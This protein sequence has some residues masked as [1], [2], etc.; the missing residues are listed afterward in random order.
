M[1]VYLRKSIK[2]GPFRVNLSKSGIGVSSGIP[3][4]RVGS[5][6]R[7]SYVRMGK[8]GVYYRKTLSSSSARG[9]AGG[10]TVPIHQAL[11]EVGSNV[12]LHDVTGADVQQLAEAFQTELTMQ[13]NEAAGTA[14]LMPLIV[15][16]YILIVTIPLGLWLRARNVARRNVVVFYDVNDQHLDK[17]ERL[18]NG[19]GRAESCGARWS[20]S[21]Q[22]AV[23]TT[24]QWKTN[25][26]ASTIVKR[27][28]AK[29]DTEGPR[30][31]KTNVAVPSLHHTRQS[32]FFLPDRVLIQEG[33]RFAEVSYSGLQVRASQTR[34]IES[35]SRPRD[36]VQVDT[37][38]KYVNKGGGPDKR[39]KNNPKLPV[40]QYGELELSSG[41]GLH[42]LWQMSSPEAS[43]SLAQSLSQ[44]A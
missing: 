13:I 37:T 28:A 32:L 39:F 11:P 17:F 41:T 40:M 38:W 42:L 23:R 31:L 30:L 7:G 8:G 18:L 19:F 1:G 44:M 14:S 15:L 22:G 24:Y 9:S 5:G 4:L 16:S 36:G 2:A 34:F 21:A 10:A 26:G 25:A 27:Q 29:A 43:T 20:V 33:R 12:E 35:G 3:G 6:P